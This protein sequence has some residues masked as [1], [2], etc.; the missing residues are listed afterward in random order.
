MNRDPGSGWA[1]W[2]FAHPIFRETLIKTPVMEPRKLEITRS[3]KKMMGF[4]HPIFFCFP[5][6]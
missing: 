1:G 3:P 6:P 4:A 2:A 5:G